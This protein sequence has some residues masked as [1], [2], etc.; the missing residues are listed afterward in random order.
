MDPNYHQPIA[1]PRKI[2]TMT[3]KKGKSIQDI[4]ELKYNKVNSCVYFGKSFTKS[5][6]LFLF[7]TII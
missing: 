7:D 1:Q 3:L 6:L 5:I 4:E 2:R